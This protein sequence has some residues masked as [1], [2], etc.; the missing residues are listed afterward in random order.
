MDWDELN[1]KLGPTV[2]TLLVSPLLS[3][4]C[5]SLAQAYSE[6]D[7]NRRFEKI[8]S[9]LEDLK[10][11]LKVLEEARIR[12]PFT[13]DDCIIFDKVMQKVQFEHREQKRKYYANYLINA[14]SHSK[15]FDKKQRFLKAIDEF[16]DLHISI[17]KYLDSVPNDVYPSIKEI[18]E[19]LN[20]QDKKRDLYPVL[21][22][23][24]GLY[25]F[26]ERSWTLDPKSKGAVLMTTNLSPENLAGNCQH[27]I[28]ELGK[29][30]LQYI[31]ST[32]E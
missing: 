32:K 28:T 4:F 11:K 20:I 14:L 19:N 17:L 23:L 18:Q 6:W 13:E 9:F 25:Y 8:E 3:P 22:E 31:I 21:S 1:D 12:E 5:G 10:E 16:T 30:F 15:E 7:T 2:R 26:V 29:E 27:K 24:C